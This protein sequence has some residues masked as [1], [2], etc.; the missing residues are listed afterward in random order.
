M[1][2]YFV[3]PSINAASGAGTVGDPYGDLQ[4][5]LDTVTRDATNGDRFNIKAGTSEILAATLGLGT[6]GTPTFS[7]GLMFSGY[8]S[9][10]GDGGIGVIDGNATYAVW[11]FGSVEGIIFDGV[12]VGNC[13][14]AAVITTDRFCA[15]RNSKIYGTSGSGLVGSSL[16]AS[17]CW[18]DDIGTIGHSGVAIDCLFTNGASNSFTTGHSGSTLV[19]SCFK[20]T[21]TSAGSNATY[22]INNSFY[23]TGSGKALSKRSINVQEQSGNLIEGFATGIAFDNVGTEVCPGWVNNN[24]FYGCTTDIAAAEFDDD[25]VNESLGAGLFD[26]SGSITSFADRLVYFNPVDQG[27]VYT[28][29]DGGMVKGAVQPARSAGGGGTSMIGPG[30]GMIGRG[31]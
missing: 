28:A 13:G 27:N 23:T 12:N 6:Y 3:D 2:S 26:L 9:A 20:L 8:T 16:I 1:S 15:I 24:A 14:S 19:R 21:S 25:W 5:A 17:N 4:H 11:N 22:A 31:Y 7:A 18:F 10:E 30:G 29:L